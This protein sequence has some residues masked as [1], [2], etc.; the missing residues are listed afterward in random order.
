MR[1]FRQWARRWLELP[2]EPPICKACGTSGKIMFGFDYASRSG[3]LCSDCRAQYHKYVTD[4]PQQ[5]EYLAASLRFRMG[6]P[7]AV[8]DFLRLEQQAGEVVDNWFRDPA[9]PYPK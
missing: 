7:A 4:W 9:T 3:V 6:D 8:P 5:A 1:R 2:G